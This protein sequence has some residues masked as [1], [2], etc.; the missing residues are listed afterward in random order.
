MTTKRQ[1]QHKVVRVYTPPKLISYGSVHV[2]TQTGSASG[3]EGTGT[4]NSARKPAG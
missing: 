4:G 1:T 3:K 2:L